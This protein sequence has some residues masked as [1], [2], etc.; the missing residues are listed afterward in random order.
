MREIEDNLLMQNFGGVNKMFYGQC[1]NGEH[2]NN[3]IC[4]IFQKIYS[5]KMCDQHFARFLSFRG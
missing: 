3:C 5:S 4:F 1:E 2:V